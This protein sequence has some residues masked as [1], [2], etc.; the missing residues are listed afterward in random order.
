MTCANWDT[1]NMSV[2]AGFHYRNALKSALHE[3]GFLMEDIEEMFAKLNRTAPHHMRERLPK[4]APANLDFVGILRTIK[5]ERGLDKDTAR[6][7]AARHPEMLFD[8][9]KYP[10]SPYPPENKKCK[11]DPEYRRTLII[12]PPAP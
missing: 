8:R 6:N 9:L 10:D 7:L 4:N 2:P 5:M 11:M 12:P 1:G 3:A